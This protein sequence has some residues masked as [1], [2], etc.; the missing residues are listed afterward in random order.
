MRVMAL[1]FALTTQPALANSYHHCVAPMINA[2]AVDALPHPEFSFR[3]TLADNGPSSAFGGQG[4]A[5]DGRDFRHLSWRGTWT[6]FEGAL[7]LAGDFWAET[8]RAK[9][10]G[11]A[12]FSNDDVMILNVDRSD[13]EEPLMI[14]CL[15]TEG[16]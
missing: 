15:P 16:A 6:H 11:R 4:F 9:W 5:F 3:L 7:Q 12:V 2:D 13:S 14:R 8:A 10:R 1:F